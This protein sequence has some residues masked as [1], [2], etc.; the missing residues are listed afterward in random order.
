MNDNKWFI[1][2]RLRG[3]GEATWNR[4]LIEGHQNLTE[5]Q[6]K[7]IVDR[8]NILAPNYDWNAMIFDEPANPSKFSQLTPDQKIRVLTALLENYHKRLREVFINLD[9]DTPCL[10]YKTTKDQLRNR[11]MTDLVLSDNGI[12]PHDDEA[13]EWLNEVLS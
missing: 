4:S 5:E 3:T 1:I 11:L 6:A 7:E 13:R 12:P 10:D 9:Y 2:F 8:Q